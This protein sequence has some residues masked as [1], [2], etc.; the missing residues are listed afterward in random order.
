[1][2][3]YTFHITVC[4]ND[5]FIYTDHLVFYCAL[6]CPANFANGWHKILEINKIYSPMT[7]KMY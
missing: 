2:K 1:M 7:Q 3:T 5:C 6:L 4:F